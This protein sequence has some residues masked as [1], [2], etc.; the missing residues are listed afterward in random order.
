MR[1]RSRLL[2]WTALLVMLFMPTSAWKGDANDGN[3]LRVTVHEPLRPQSAARRARIQR[4]LSRQRATTRSLQ[5]EDANV[6]FLRNRHERRAAKDRIEAV[7]AVHR[8]ELPLMNDDVRD[9]SLV[10]G[11]K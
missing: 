3:G 9:T 8:R 11:G 4:A 6:A 2:W 5:R 7:T 10:E 1:L